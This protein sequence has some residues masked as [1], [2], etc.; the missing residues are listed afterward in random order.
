LSPAHAPSARAY[1]ATAPLP[2]G[3]VLMFGGTSSR[4]ASNDTWTFNGTDWQNV[5]PTVGP[6]PSPRSAL[7]AAGV[8]AS[9]STGYVLVFGGWKTS[10]VFADTWA[11]GANA[12][13]AT[14]GLASPPA[15]DVNQSTT[16]ST[17]GFG[18]TSNISYAWTS[19][20]SGCQPSSVGGGVRLTCRPTAPGNYTATVAVS[21]SS[22][23]GSISVSIPFTVNSRPL[24]TSVRVAPYP[25]IL[26]SGNLTITV[27]ATGGTGIL[28]YAYSGLP[29]GCSSNDTPFL[30]CNPLVAG[31]WSVQVTAHDAT[32]ASANATA[33]VVVSAS[34]PAPPNRLLQRLTSPLVIVGAIVVVG[35]LLLGAYAYR[36]RHPGPPRSGATG[37]GPNVPEPP[38]Q[39]R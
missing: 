18:P 6:P 15:I 26:T 31:T 11:I 17:T 32:N 20:P 3:T 28:H 14:R 1:A 2:N 22:V 10:A 5:S 27:T 38:P 21:S 29:T 39:V 36:R 4:I 9:G 8:A 35:V 16:L 23:T 33:S 30:R 19:S 12:L 34:G 24:I 25:E 37:T 7:G 13:F